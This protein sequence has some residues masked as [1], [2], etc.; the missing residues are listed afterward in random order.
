MKRCEM[1]QQKE[2]TMLTLILV[3]FVLLG[4]G[5]MFIGLPLYSK[6][7]TKLKNAETYIRK[8]AVLYQQYSIPDIQRYVR[9]RKHV[10]L[11]EQEAIFIV[12]RLRYENGLGPIKYYNTQLAEGR[13]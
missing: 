6:P 11:T 9:R 13:V 12:Q 4:L 2:E 1:Q 10:G 5:C 7:D 3:S 8:H